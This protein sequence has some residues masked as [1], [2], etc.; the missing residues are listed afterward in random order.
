MSGHSKWA[1]IKVRKGAQDAKRGKMFTKITK[2]II[3]AAKLGGADPD[4]NPRLRA[5]IMAAKGVNMPNDNVKRAI[6]RG[7]G[8]LG[9]EN[10]EEIIYEG[11]GPQGV[12]ILV[13]ATS[14]NRNRTTGEIRHTFTKY[15]GNL[16]V[17]GCVSRIFDRKGQ[18]TVPAEGLTEDDV[19]EAVLEA[20]AEDME[21]EGDSFIVTTAFEDLHTVA[22]ALKEAEIPQTSVEA[23]WIPNL[24]VNVAG[25]NAK[26]LLKLMDGLE[27]NDDVTNVWANF[28][29]DDA[30]L[31]AL[32]AE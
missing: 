30:E 21:K 1:N 25:D 11:F 8:E 27:D 12:A 23:V 17:T 3:I 15:G 13:E 26:G 6:Q 31:E 9:A 32:G 20:G 4:G 5:A 24:T 7:S 16:G 18:I 22:E 28:D 14:D 19:F 29:I 2:E 10:I